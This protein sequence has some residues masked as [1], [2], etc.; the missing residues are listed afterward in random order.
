MMKRLYYYIIGVGLLLMVACDI[1]SSDNGDL[2]GFWQLRSVDTLATGGT[3][4]MRLSQITWAIQGT[5]LETRLAT[6]FDYKCD[7][8]F[9]F[10]HTADA[11]TLHSPYLSQRDSGDI[12]VEMKDIEL[13]RPFGINKLEERF[14]ILELNSDAMTL[15]SDWLRLWFRKY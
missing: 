1:E 13:L 8:I 9:H 12:K 7:I 2:D 4:D 14:R 6:T 11:L 15:E 3:T 10:E 5:L